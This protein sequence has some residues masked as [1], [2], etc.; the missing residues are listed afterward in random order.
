MYE[1][2]RAQFEEVVKRVNAGDVGDV[3]VRS[4]SGRGMY[5]RNCVAVEIDDNAEAWSI[6]FGFALAEV[7]ADEAGGDRGDYEV[8]GEYEGSIGAWVDQDEHTNVRT[9]SMGRGLVLYWPDTSFV[10]PDEDDEEES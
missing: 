7:I 1:I 9:D 3:A 10:G 5:G 6:G 2:E 4:Y 8:R